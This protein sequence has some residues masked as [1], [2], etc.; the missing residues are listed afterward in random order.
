MLAMVAAAGIAPA[1]SAQPVPVAQ[2]GCALTAAPARLPVGGSLHGVLTC[3]PWV[4][5]D[6][7]MSGAA[8]V[9]LGVV[10]GWLQLN[11]PLADAA[12][13]AAVACFSGAQPGVAP[14]SFDASASDRVFVCTAWYSLTSGAS[15]GYEYDADH[16]ERNG[17]QCIEARRQRD[18]GVVASPPGILVA[19]EFKGSLPGPLDPG[20][21]CAGCLSGLDPWTRDIYDAVLAVGIS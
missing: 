12:P 16:D 14:V 9:P 20:V 7:S 10:C 8:V 5:P 18:T 2:S 1:A 15:S 21:N 13:A 19:R 17:T 3:G 11:E 6:P 4:E